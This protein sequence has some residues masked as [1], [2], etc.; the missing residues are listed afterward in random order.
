MN[1]LKTA[2]IE[3]RL[4]L[5]ELQIIYTVLAHIN[6][7]RSGGDIRKTI[8]GLVDGLESIAGIQYTIKEFD[9]LSFVNADTHENLGHVEIVVDE[10]SIDIE[11]NVHD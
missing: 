2:G 3:V 5:E 4:S 1:I 10:N 8:Q 6:V 7:P 9:R 11:E